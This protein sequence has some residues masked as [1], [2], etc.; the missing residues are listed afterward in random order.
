[1]YAGTSL[2]VAQALYLGIEGSQNFSPRQKEIRRR[3]F[4]ACF[5]VDRH[6]S[7]SCNKPFTVSFQSPHTRLPYPENVLAFD[8]IYAGFTVED[9]SREAHQVSQ[10]GIMP[11]FIAMVGLWGEMAMLHV[12]GGRRRSKHGPHSPESDFHQYEKAIKEFALTCLHI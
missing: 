10:F 9:L 12:S 8:E 1:M 5:V 3:T 2:R 4:W 11:F 7:Y 6:V